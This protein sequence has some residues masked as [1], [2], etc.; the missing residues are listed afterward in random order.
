MGLK[1]VVVTGLGAITPVGNTVGAYW[2]AL[3]AG[4]SGAA[5]I[6]RFDATKFRTRF[7]CEVKGYNPDDHFDRKEVKKM[8]LFTQFAMVA[9]AEAVQDAHLLDG[10]DKDRVGV[11]WGSGIGG[12]K[13]LQDECVAFGRGDGTPRFSPF[14]IPRMIADLAAGHISI[15]YG[16]RGPNF[17]TVSACA[18]AS[19]AVIDAYNYI[20][21]GMADA[22]VT[23]GSEAAITES[24]I[25][26][27]NA[28]RAMSERN[29]D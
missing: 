11:I 29:D 28:L 19:N 3:R 16:F 18:S 12:L 22:I 21:L 1:R 24:G 14:F 8:D 25:G 26:G 17:V 13:S 4:T 10:V 20:R 9:A 2:A 27:F 5:P 6:T 7:A 23:G 15:K